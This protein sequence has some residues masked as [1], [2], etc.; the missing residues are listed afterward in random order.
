MCGFYWFFYLI[1]CF[2]DSNFF[3]VV[4]IINVKMI[5][6]IKCIFIIIIILMEMDVRVNVVG[7]FFCNCLGI[8]W[9]SKILMIL[10]RIIFVLLIN[11]LII[12]CF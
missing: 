1:F 11:G 5:V 8:W 10:L 2:S 3:I 6:G 4:L 12:V 7:N 9:V